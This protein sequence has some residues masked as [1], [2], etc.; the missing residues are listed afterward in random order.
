MDLP[1]KK[2]VK[3]TDE[4][5]VDWTLSIGYLGG[6]AKALTT[7]GEICSDPDVVVSASAAELTMGKILCFEVFKKLEAVIQEI[8]KR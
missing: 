3:E 5:K 4:V 7:V 8:D 1:R 6:V 2:D